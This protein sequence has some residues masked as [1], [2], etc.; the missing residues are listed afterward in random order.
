MRNPL[1]GF[2]TKYDTAYDQTPASFRWE[3]TVPAEPFGPGVRYY[4]EPIDLQMRPSGLHGYS[5]ADKC[6]IIPIKTFK[7]EIPT[8]DPIGHVIPK[9]LQGPPAPTVSAA[10]LKQQKRRAKYEDE[11]LF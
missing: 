5:R 1:A 8:P 4:R 3:H 10:M 9:P 6:W 2:K 7:P 11:A